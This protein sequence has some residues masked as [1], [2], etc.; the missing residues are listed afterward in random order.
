MASKQSQVIDLAPK[1]RPKQSRSQASFEAVVEACARLLRGGGYDTLTTNLIAEVAGV[2]IA[3]L[4]EY[5]PNK[6]AIVAAVA[7][8][9]VARMATRLAESF[10]A[11]QALDDREATHFWIACLVEIVSDDA[12]LY[13]ALIDHY[14]EIRDS[15]AWKL[16]RQQL[17]QVA[18]GRAASIA[19][20]LGLDDF[21][22]DSHLIA[23]MGERAILDI[24]LNRAHDREAMTAR[25]GE[26][27]YR[28]IRTR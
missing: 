5:F 6:E 16:L 13:R 3:T 8:Q 7:E 14:P 2:G 25:L 18:L 12:F 1:K 11:A 20:R 15:K 19:D 9:T 28:I 23:I 24:A 4:Y 10:D 17:H 27:L 22:R 21:E 26:L